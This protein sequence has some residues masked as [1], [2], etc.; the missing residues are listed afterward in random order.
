MPLPQ[1]LPGLDT[2]NLPGM[3]PVSIGPLS[4]TSGKDG[5]RQPFK[6]REDFD[7]KFYTAICS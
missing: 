5:L 6:D 7:D 2:I 1:N 3:P 4:N